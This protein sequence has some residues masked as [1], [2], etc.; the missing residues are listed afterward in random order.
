VYQTIAPPTPLELDGITSINMLHGEGGA[1]QFSLLVDG[2][3]TGMT[4]NDATCLHEYTL[5]TRDK[6]FKDAGNKTHRSV[7]EGYLRVAVCVKG[8]TIPS[9]TQPFHSPLVPHPTIPITV[10][11]PGRTALHHFSRFDAHTVY[12]NHA[13]GRGYAKFH[14]IGSITYVEVPKIVQ[15]VQRYA[16]AS[17]PA[18]KAYVARPIYAIPVSPDHVPNAV[19]HIPADAECLLW[20]Q[21]LGQVNPRKLADLHKYVKRIPKITMPS[22]VD[23]CMTCWVYKIRRY[24]CGSQDTR[25]DATLT[26]QGISMDW[27]FICHNSKTKGRYKK[28]VGMYTESAYIINTDH[29]LYLLW[30]FPYNSKRPPVTWLNLWLIR[31]APRDTTHKYCCM[32]QWGEHRK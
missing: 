1:L 11:S 10:L 2:G 9:H 21:L 8:Q 30:G 12:T 18:I 3:A 14:V 28:L 5:L 23:K 32:D 7:E 26:G 20:H 6:Y 4:F 15:G 17:H 19:N 16:Q 31:Y 27:G 22:D 29:H 25:Q 24:D 13:S